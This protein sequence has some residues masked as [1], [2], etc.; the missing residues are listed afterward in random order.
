MLPEEGSS[1]IPFYS[2]E[3]TEVRQQW[4]QKHLP[5]LFVMANSKLEDLTYNWDCYFFFNGKTMVIDVF[6]KSCN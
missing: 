1:Q 4:V 5:I 2:L 6:L 3:E